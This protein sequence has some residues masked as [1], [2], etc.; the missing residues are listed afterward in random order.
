M[1]KHL[2]KLTQ[3]TIN[4]IDKSFAVNPRDKRAKK[5]AINLE[6]YLKNIDI[7]LANFI[8]IN[9]LLF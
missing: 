1:T 6:Q 8:E 5:Y 2:M 4:S 9:V 7:K 3:I